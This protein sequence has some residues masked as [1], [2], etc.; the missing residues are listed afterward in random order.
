MK[1]CNDLNGR[2]QS[3]QS[4]STVDGP[5]TR[6]VVFFQGCPVSCIFC[7]NPDS[8]KMDAGEIISVDDLLRRLERFRVFLYQPGLTLSGGEPLAQPDFALKLA[9]KAHD[10]GW[11]VALDTSGWGNTTTLQKITAYCQLVIFSIKHP[12][13]P[14]LVSKAKH[15][16]T[17]AN[18]HSLA[19]LNIPVWLR[20]V[21]IPNLTDQP[22]ALTAL[23]DL[24]NQV[25]NLQRLEI[26][27]FN[28]LAASKWSKLGWE[29][30]LFQGEIPLVTE[31]QIK[32][33]ATI[34]ATVLKR[35][36]LIH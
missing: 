19:E 28:Q 9:Q 4:Y 26:L 33:A 36:E 5:G 12:L 10:D 27:P 23:G 32:K 31:A 25:P 7:H 29:N 30:P 8:W 3:I 2:I 18:W 6:C 15:E 13:T 17:L 24:A 20:Y 22:D 34:V 16:Q 11:Q 35:P 1:E 21:L 14:A